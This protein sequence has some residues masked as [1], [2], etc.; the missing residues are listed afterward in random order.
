MDYELF[1]RQFG[2]LALFLGT[3]LEGETF[4]F[5]ASLAAFNG[6]LTPK[7]VFVT[8]YLGS[9]LGDQIPFL[10]GRFH[11]REIL[12]RRPKWRKRCAKV[13]R[14]LDRHRLKVLLFYRFIYGFRG[15]TPFV[16][17][18]TSMPTKF[19][20]AVNLVVALV[21]TL[22]VGAAGYFLGHTL[23]NL[24]INFKV[25]QMLIALGL[26]VGVVG[27]LAVRAR[28]NGNGSNGSPD[29]SA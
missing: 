12:N 2:Y 25:I 21:W 22:L 17:G 8:A 20:V 15:V 27:F 5:L 6:L 14:W 24:G 23:Q 16:F 29:D 7:Y 28:R 19:F 11:G 4:L 13:F 9:M 1:L 18:L 3:M 10:L 26:A